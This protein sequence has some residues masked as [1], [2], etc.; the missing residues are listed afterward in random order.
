MKRSNLKTSLRESY[1]APSV[2]GVLTPVALNVLADFS[3]GG[4]VE[5]FPDYE[6]I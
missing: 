2:L 6:E 1:V 5:E 3:F 4:E